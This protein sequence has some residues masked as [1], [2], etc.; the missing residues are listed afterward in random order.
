MGKENFAIREENIVKQNIC[1]AEQ[2]KETAH[3]VFSTMYKI[4]R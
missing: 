1:E 4:K 3:V 2:F